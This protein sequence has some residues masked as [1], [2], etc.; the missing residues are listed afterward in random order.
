MRREHYV[1]RMQPI[2]VKAE[3]ALPAISPEDRID[4]GLW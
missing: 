1:V 3:S 4:Q 2:S